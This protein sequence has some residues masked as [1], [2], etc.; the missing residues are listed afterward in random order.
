MCTP[1]VS[2]YSNRISLR[3]QFQ[4]LA[5][6]QRSC[7]CLSTPLMS[8]RF[9]YQ[10]TMNTH[11]LAYLCFIPS[12]APVIATPTSTTGLQSPP[13]PPSLPPSPQS[14]ED[15]TLRGG[16]PTS[17]GLGTN[18]LA[19]SKSSRISKPDP[20]QSQDN[21][22]YDTPTTLPL[23]TILFSH[24]GSPTSANPDPGQLRPVTPI[25]SILLLGLSSLL[26]SIIII[27][28]SSGFI[29]GDSTTLIFGGPVAMIN[30]QM[31]S[32][33]SEPFNPSNEEQNDGCSLDRKL[34][35]STSIHYMRDDNCN[36][37]PHHIRLKLR[38]KSFPPRRHSLP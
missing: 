25:T 10:H 20:S 31:V 33:V 35:K 1:M 19:T 3:Q 6:R 2:S 15:K 37:V 22:A 9:R 34:R 13:S 38:R 24:S 7:A 5:A 29:S 12:L 8:Q 28:S 23:I 27:P 4:L 32:V 26:A 11:I 18:P 21:P 16:E 17:S 30:Q 14:K 36:V